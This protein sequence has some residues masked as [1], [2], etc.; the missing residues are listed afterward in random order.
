LSPVPVDQL[1]ERRLTEKNAKRW[2]TFTRAMVPPVAMTLARR[3]ERDWPAKLLYV[4]F[5][6][7]K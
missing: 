4:S 5:P 3:G 7:Q 6:E 1:F 2:P